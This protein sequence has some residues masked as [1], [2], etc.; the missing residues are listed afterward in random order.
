M[1]DNGVY[2]HGMAKAQRHSLPEKAR[3][4]LEQALAELEGKPADRW[5]ARRAKRLEGEVP[6]YLLIAPKGWRAV[7]S[8]TENNGIAV[9][10]ITHVKTL[11]FLQGNDQR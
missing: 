8:P 11:R 9:H 1:K 10:F 2:W 3:E 4:G 5:S 7:I 6:K